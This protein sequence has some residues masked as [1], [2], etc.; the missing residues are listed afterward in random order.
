MLDLLLEKREI[1]EVLKN[2]ARCVDSFDFEGLARLY[3]EDGELVTPWGG[4]RGRAG[5]AAHVEKDLGAYLALHHVS[6]GHQIDVV[7]GAGRARARMTLLASHVND[8]SGR[9]FSTSGGHYEIDL[10]REHG[11]WRLA[12]VQIFPAW[13]FTTEGGAEPGAD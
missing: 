13:T 2:L 4:H 6:A 11:L 12:R 10:V 1:T 5:L 8:E 7:P 9:S 3:A